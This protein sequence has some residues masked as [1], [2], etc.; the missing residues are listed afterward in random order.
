MFAITG[1]RRR[2]NSGAAFSFLRKLALS[3]AQSLLFNACLAQRMKDGLFRKVLPGDVMM[4][5]PVGGMFTAEDLVVEQAPPDSTVDSLGKMS[6]AD[7]DRPWELESGPLMRA[8]LRHLPDGTALL[9]LA[10]HHLVADGWSL[11]VLWR[12]LAAL[13]AAAAQGRAPDLPVLPVQYADYGVWQRAWLKGMRVDQ[14][15]AYWRDRLADAPTR[16]ELP[17]DRPRPAVQGH[18]G[19]VVPLRLGPKLTGAL[20][21]LAG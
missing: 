15:I 12:D 18:R 2:I 9:L 14:Q 8:R 10:I 13:Y 20:R 17:S 6:A 11:G 3:A 4:K 7:A 1:P 19:G 21:R 16:L 5:W